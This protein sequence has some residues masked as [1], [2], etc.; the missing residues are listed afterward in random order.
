MTPDVS[1]LRAVLD[2][3]EPRP[4]RAGRA[5][6]W[7][8]EARSYR[9]VGIYDVTASEIAAIAWTGPTAPAFP[10]F[11]RSQGLSGAAVASGEPVVVQDVAADPRYLT[12]FGSTRA[13]AI[14]PVGGEA[15]GPVVGTLDVESDRRNAFAPE[16]V[17]FLTACASALA[18]LWEQGADATSA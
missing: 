2:A 17:R 11:P 15:G 13:E 10:R 3:I 14:F 1:G 5:A 16:D 18:V 4:V 6:E 9:W 7:I 8:R 12:A